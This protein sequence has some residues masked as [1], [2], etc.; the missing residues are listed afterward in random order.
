MV[1]QQIKPLER[2]GKLDPGHLIGELNFGFSCI[3]LDRRYEHQQLFLP[4]L[5]QAVFPYL[6]NR[7]IYLIRE[8]FNSI[9]RPRNRMYHYKPIWHWRDLLK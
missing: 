5:L 3:L 7:K 1:Q 6:E 4:T 9:R 8:R 2:I